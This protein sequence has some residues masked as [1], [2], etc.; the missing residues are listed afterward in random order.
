MKPCP[1]FIE[2]YPLHDKDGFIEFCTGMWL[3]TRDLVGP[4]TAEEV[5]ETLAGFPAERQSD[6]ISLL[7]RRGQLQESPL[8]ERA[9]ETMK[10]HTGVPVN[11]ANRLAA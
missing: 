11:W 7:I 10:D 9:L 2:L 8:Y 6:V 1:A 3:H 4:P 5:R